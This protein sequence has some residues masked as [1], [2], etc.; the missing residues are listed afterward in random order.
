MIF[1][2]FLGEVYPWYLYLSTVCF[3]PICQHF[4]VFC[5][6]VMSNSLKVHGLQH[7]RPPCLLPSPTH[8]H[9]VSD[10]IQSSCPLSFTSLPAFYLSQHQGLF[11]WVG[12]SH[13]VAKWLELQFQHQPF[14]EFSGLISFRIDWFDPLQ[15]KGLSRV[16]SNTIVR[17]DQ[18]FG[19]QP[20]LWFKSHISTW[21]LEKVTALTMQTF[22]G[23]AMSLFFN[24]LSRF[25][26]AFLPRSKHL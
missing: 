14:N 23:K 11:Q 19:S 25:V 3:N 13:Q 17:K 12:S 7:V 21:L 22:V 8:V 20:S 9:W 4:V 24:T 5:P 15:S 26:I 18:F 2:S 16:F 6:S 1:E 10:V